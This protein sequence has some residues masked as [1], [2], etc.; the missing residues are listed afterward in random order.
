MVSIMDELMDISH[1]DGTG[2]KIHR[3]VLKAAQVVDDAVKLARFATGKQIQVRTSIPPELCLC[4]ARGRLVQVLTGLISQ[5]ALLGP[6]DDAVVVEA[7]D[8][9]AGARFA[10][11][12]RGAHGHGLATRGSDRFWRARVPTSGI[13]ASDGAK[14]GLAVAKGIVE[15]HGGEVWAT[16]DALGTAFH[17]T[18]PHKNAHS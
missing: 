4:A 13:R 1:M 7:S 2:L 15:A 12:A 8:G 3:E 10:V 17:F 5:A 18:L 16:A 9:D 14:P 6:R 11:I